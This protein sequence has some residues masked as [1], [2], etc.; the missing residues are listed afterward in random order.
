LKLSAVTASRVALQA[1]VLAGAAAWAGAAAPA[2]APERIEELV[3]AS[4]LT[5]QLAQ[6]EP[7]L[8]R[9]FFGDGDGAGGGDAELDVASRQRLEKALASAYGSAAL[10]EAVLEELAR[11]MTTADVDD[12]LKF[13]R[14]DLGRRVTRLE[15][16]AGEEAETKKRERDGQDLLKVLPEKR[17]EVLKRLGKAADAGP[18]HATLVIQMTVGIARGLQSGLPN[19]N[20]LTVETLREEMEGERARLIEEGYADALVSMA[21]TYR[22]LPDDE[23]AAYVRFAESPVGRRYHDATGK[24]LERTLER[25]ASRFGLILSGGQRST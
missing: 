15:E 24:A 4:G 16:E 18:Q 9:S 1:F 20:S 12:V 22:A 19:V 21:H 6:V 3:D 25:A 10:R 11:S 8:R 2:V 5:K 14:S 17:V 23:L 7:G 13:L